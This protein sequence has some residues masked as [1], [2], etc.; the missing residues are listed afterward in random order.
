MFE[1]I[2]DRQSG[3]FMKTQRVLLS[4]CINYGPKEDHCDCMLDSKKVL[5]DELMTPKRLMNM[6]L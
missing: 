4:K 2:I 3:P 5:V 6:K 1:W